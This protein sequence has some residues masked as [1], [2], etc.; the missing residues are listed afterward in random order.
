MT[1][2][3]Q[4]KADLVRERLTSGLLG[5]ERIQVVKAPPGA[6]KTY[7]LIQLLTAAHAAGMRCAVGTFTNA[8]AD[9]ICRRLSETSP[10]VRIVRFA[11]SSPLESDL[12]NGIEIVT[13]AGDL[14]RGPSVVVASTAKWAFYER[15]PFDALL[16]DEA[17]QISW[18]DFLVL[19]P[20]SARFVLIGDPGQIP[21]VVS[22][23]TARWETS[24]NAPHRPVPER[25]CSGDFADL[26]LEELPGSRRLPADAVNLVNAF[27]DFE[28]GAFAKPDERF[29]RVPGADVADPVGSALARLAETS[30]VGVTL[31]TPADGPPMELDDDVAELV[32]TLAQALLDGDAVVSHSAATAKRPVAM[33]PEDIGIVATHR[34]MNTRMHYRLPKRLQGKVRVETPE[35]WQGLER[36]VMIAVHPLS[37][38]TEPSAFDLETGRLCVMASR[39]QA[40]LLVVSRDHVP[41]TLAEHI[42]SAEHPVGRPDGAGIGLDRHTR[43]WDELTARDAIVTV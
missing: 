26:V 1:A 42:I 31:P 34:A 32:S 28:F 4:R 24:G 29:V 30:I 23:A 8:Q 13:N 7:L 3:L 36:K 18:S 15:E 27:Y 12:P 11:G 20:L 5:S 37:G 41:R 43:F 6:G 16:I 9:D 22:I 21:P 39:H 17:W 35:R 33:T 2:E 19:L 14:P 10:E 25:L 38:V 40:G